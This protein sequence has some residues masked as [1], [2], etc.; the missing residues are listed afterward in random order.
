MKI[1][2]DIYKCDKIG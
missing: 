2:D 1:F